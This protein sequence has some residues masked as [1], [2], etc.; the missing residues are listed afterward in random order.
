MV[1]SPI[2]YFVSQDFD[3]TP[4]PAGHMSDT[5]KAFIEKYMGISPGEALKKLPVTAGDPKAAVLPEKEISLYQTLRE[6]DFVQLV[7]FYIGQQLFAMPTLAIQEVIR[8]QEISLLPLAP[9][10]ISGVINLRGHVTPLIRL[11]NWLDVPLEPDAEDKFTI[12]CRSSGLQFGVEIE[13]LQTMYKVLQQDLD[14][15]AEMSIGANVDFVTGM[16][17]VG[18]KIIPIVS[19]D[20]IVENMLKL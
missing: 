17:E 5:E 3:T 8:R 11:R 9:S 12:I 14:W 1:K 2:E 18:E 19:T 10:F 13:K 15:D 16:F 6:A 4:D 20:R 7:G